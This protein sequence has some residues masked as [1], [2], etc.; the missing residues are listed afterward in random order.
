MDQKAVNI[1]VE[2]ILKVLAS[3]KFRDTIGGT[4][5]NLYNYVAGYTVGYCM[6]L[7][8]VDLL[9]FE[10]AQAVNCTIVSYFKDAKH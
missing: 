1:V 5:S 7:V 4:E 3:R 9:S 2:R 6:A 10:E 8:F